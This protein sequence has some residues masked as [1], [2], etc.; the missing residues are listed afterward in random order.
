[1]FD[2]GARLGVSDGTI[3]YAFFR[4]C[5]ACLAGHT[6]C[7][8]DGCREDTVIDGNVRTVVCSVCTSKCPYISAQSGINSQPNSSSKAYIHTYVHSVGNRSIQ[9]MSIWT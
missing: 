8:T 5:F 6:E 1:M 9:N 4:V 3:I 2:E 7:N